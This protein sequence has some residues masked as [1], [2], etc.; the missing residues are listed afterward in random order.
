MNPSISR[1]SLLAFTRF[2][3]T[4]YSLIVLYAYIF[5]V[6]ITVCSSYNN[7]RHILDNLEANNLSWKQMLPEKFLLVN[8]DVYSRNEM[9]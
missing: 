9:S 3:K 2:F 5:L 1:I 4:L 7:T 6:Q 8:V